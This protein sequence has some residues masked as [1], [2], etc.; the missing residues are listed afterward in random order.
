MRTTGFALP[1]AGFTTAVASSIM[2]RERAFTLL[3]SKLSRLMMAL[4]VIS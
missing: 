4:R 3:A 1:I 2:L